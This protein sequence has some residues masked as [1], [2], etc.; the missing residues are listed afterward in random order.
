MCYKTVIEG[1][2]KYKVHLST[3]PNTATDISK[4]TYFVK[5]LKMS[6]PIYLYHE[7]MLTSKS[8]AIIPSRR[9][10]QPFCRNDEGTRKIVRQQFRE[11][12]IIQRVGDRPFI[13]LNFHLHSS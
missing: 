4:C 12:F 13:D 2:S 7:Q 5:N 3:C 10:K 9:V 6:I 8:L 11:N 1:M